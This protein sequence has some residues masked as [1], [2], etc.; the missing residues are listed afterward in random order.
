M[1]KTEAIKRFLS[2][3]GNEHLTNLYYYGMEVQV[4]VAQDNG[5]RTSGV[6]AGKRWSGWEDPDTGERWKSF[7]IPWNS[8]SE[9]QYEDSEMSFDLATHVEGIG[10]TGWDWQEQK[11]RWVG[12]DFDSIT[13]HK[14]GLTDEELA[15]VKQKVLSLPYVTLIKSTSGKGIH[16]YIHFD[17]PIATATH[18]EHAALARS[19]L[20]LMSG[21]VGY[22][23][24]N[25]VDICG[26]ILWVYH[27]KQE[28]TDGL[29]M[30]RKG[31]PLSLN[32]IPTNW[33]DHLL[34]T[35]GRKKLVKSISTDFDELFSTIKFVPLDGEHLA[36]L[37]W[38]S[39]KGTRDNWWDSDHNMLVCHTLD[40]AQ[41]H[42]D[43]GM[44]GIFHTDSSG[45]SSQNC[46]AFP[47]T[48]GAWVVRRHGLGVKE[49]PSWSS[50]LSGWTKCIF[51]AIADLESCSRSNN[52]IESIKDGFVFDMAKQGIQ[53]LKDVG[54]DIDI[55]EKLSTRRMCIKEKS[56]K[57]IVTVERMD[58]DP[59][60]EGFLKNKKGDLWERVIK[61]NKPRKELSAPDNLV[62]HCISN[63]TEAGWY[64]FAR[65][66]WVLQNRSNVNT[67]LLSQ[68]EV[69]N[70]QDVEVLM[71][72]AILNPWEIV[73]IPFADE[74][75]GN[76]QW[77]KDAA[78]ISVAPET[79]PC[80][81]WLSLLGH[82][83]SSLTDS[84][85]ANQ[86]CIDNA[87]KTGGE[88]LLCWLASMFQRPCEPLPYLFLV[89]DQNTG[90][91][92][93]HEAVG[94]LLI[95]RGYVRADNALLNNSGFNAEVANAVLC[96]VE[97][98]NL[99]AN[100]EAA[101]RIKDWVTGKTISIRAMYKNAYDSINTTHWIQCANDPTYCPVL[102][103]DTRIMV[104]RVEKLRHEIPKARLFEELKKER[105]GFL[106]LVL[107]L[108][109]P[110]A[111]GRLSIPC[112]N[113][114]DK[115]E[116]EMDSMNDLEAFLHHE[117]KDCLGNLIR[118]D[119]FFSSFIAWLPSEKRSYWNSM[120]A[121]KL[122]PKKGNLCKG[123]HGHDNTTYIANVKFRSDKASEPTIKF[124]LNQHN[125]RLE[126]CQN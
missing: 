70:S 56:D 28:G 16:I 39:E 63:G 10:M 72:K 95:K 8:D 104:I 99:R 106:K 40:L 69:S 78:A 33:K 43:L 20:S 59:L 111:P 54:I 1:N 120:K 105:A 81:T 101:N 90:K 98:T 82:C 52:G 71:S 113:T 124:K 92:T 97:E 123:K 96:V 100:K 29:S 109:L 74:Y 79:G 2:T 84:V 125:G 13:N 12:F 108:D 110:D 26:G 48:G 67:V 11:S 122:F 34:V 53:A 94:Q 64:I 66:G 60:L 88:Y 15:L 7:R 50:D 75:P 61:H 86:W 57:L 114:L 31:V 9:P 103:G 18:T 46:F 19:L 76:R 73:N 42:S 21:E 65:G 49:H 4:N 30:V 117:T 3:T 93:L 116:L 107:N 23:L 68:D 87:I 5:Q 80:E 17:E 36:L 85:L 91:S 102:P 37:K 32:K 47:L 51:N 24:S 22:N 55:P 38:L 77:N 14:A 121:A 27:R 126:Q 35:T 58:S 118:W 62:R 83:G 89:G 25:S 115:T 41:A 119:D 45:S 44:K 112:L 6:Y